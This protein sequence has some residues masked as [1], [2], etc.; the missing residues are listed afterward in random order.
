MNNGSYEK[1]NGIFNTPEDL[2][3]FVANLAIKHPDS[4]I[5]DPCYGECSLLQAAHECLLHIGC[6]EPS[7]YL[8]GYDITPHTGTMP[9]LM[10][11]LFHRG[12]LI[13]R[14]FFTSS[15][16]QE[17]KKFDIVLMNPPFVRHHLIPKDTLK[18]IKAMT[19]H[20]LGLP[21]TSDLWAYF[22]IHSSNFIRQNGS[23]VAILPWSFLQAD[24]ARPVREFLVESFR[25]LRVIVIGKRLFKK[26]EERVLVLCA[27]GFGNPSSE[28]SVNY[29]FDI[30]TA[31]N[32]WIPVEKD[33]W[34]K[35][36]WDAL[37]SSDI[38]NFLYNFASALGFEPL[39]HF[40]KIRIGTVTG[41]NSFFIL[42]REK[43]RRMRLSEDIL[44]P[45]V[46]HSNSIN[47]FVG[48]VSDSIS[49]VL[50]LIPGDHIPSG[51]L[52]AYIEMGER[53][54]LND[55]YHTSKRAKWY[56]I[57]SQMTPDAFLPYMTK[58]V[59]FLVLNPER[60]LSTNTVHGVYFLDGVDRQTRK[61]IQLSM[62]TSFA[63]LSVEL[64][65]RTYGGGVLK[66]EPSAAVQ[67]LVY[68]GSGRRFPRQLEIKLN[69]MLTSGKRLE[70]VKQVDDWFITNLS[71]LAEDISFISQC[72]EKLRY[73][74][75]R[76][77]DENRSPD[78]KT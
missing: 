78:G 2:A 33:T 41:A 52:E 26:A 75:L 13:E 12:N 51:A 31:Y 49:D 63:Q 55:R 67:I 5:L 61:W 34:L 71:I 11:N 64:T 37:V 27:E 29:S 6:T 36:P 40:A 65:A 23:L 76:K 70:A 10:D 48:S 3:Q 16:D 66:V 8:F 18:R 21:M 46:T 20:I 25:L 17:E 24:Y 60:L 38:R 58:E 54:R 39:G 30:P 28:I 15:K 7:N 77:A 43:A 19:N 1:H 35:S 14:D 45:I 74:R 47:R 9:S 69:K 56:S 32:N 68:P 72:Y 4:T 59:P 73:L 22:V 44:V 53:D 62:L 57:P 42:D 50:L